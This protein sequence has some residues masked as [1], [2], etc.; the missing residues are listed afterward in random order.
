[1]KKNILLLMAASAMLFGCAAPNRNP[2]PMPE[3]TQPVEMEREAVNNPG[4]MFDPNRAEYLYDDNRAWRVGD[5]V[6]VVVTENTTAR[7]TAETTAERETDVNFGISAFPTEGPLGLI[8]GPLGLNDPEKT[9]IRANAT[10]DFEGTGETSRES[11]FSATVATRI[12]KRLPGNVLQVEGARRIQV[13]NETQILV[14]RG[15]MRQRDIS[16]DNTVPSAN[17][18]QAQ[19]EL[20]GNGVLADKQKPGWLSRILDNI[21]PF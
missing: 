3:L 14:V 10:N 15:L 20:Y 16:S 21:Y 8:G 9:R 2:T 19:I 11:E 13:N 4:S 5:I 1:M 17:L 6:M 12:V 7:H 18:A